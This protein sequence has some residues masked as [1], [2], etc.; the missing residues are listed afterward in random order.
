MRRDAEHNKNEHNL[1]P[2]ANLFFSL[3]PFL[4]RF[5]KFGESTLSRSTGDMPGDLDKVILRDEH[6]CRP[7]LEAAQKYTVAKIAV[8]VFKL[9]LPGFPN[10]VDLSSEIVMLACDS[11]PKL[12]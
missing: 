11:I 2:S 10:L 12:K 7:D 4:G 3:C 1:V 5:M 9:D 6:S 8:A